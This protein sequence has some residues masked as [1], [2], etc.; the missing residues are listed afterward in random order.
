[1]EQSRSRNWLDR[2]KEMCA[3]GGVIHNNVGDNGK[4]THKKKTAF[5][6]PGVSFRESFPLEGFTRRAYYE[7]PTEFARHISARRINFLSLAGEGTRHFNRRTMIR[8]CI[9][10]AAEYRAVIRAYANVQSHVRRLAAR[11]AVCPP[12]SASQD[13][14]HVRL[15]AVRASGRVIASHTAVIA[16]P[17]RCSPRH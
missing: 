5:R 13:T 1:M 16:Q 14:A 4:F 15:R 7:I 6:V 12:V 3:R 9:I 8:A 2:S 11:P 17:F 10:V